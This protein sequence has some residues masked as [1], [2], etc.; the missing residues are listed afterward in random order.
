VAV[1]DCPEGDGDLH[2]NDEAKKPDRNPTS[3]VRE[4]ASEGN[5]LLRIRDSF[6]L[7]EADLSGL[8]PV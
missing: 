6:C 8:R 4:S 3:L 5:N 7:D 2:E 1:K